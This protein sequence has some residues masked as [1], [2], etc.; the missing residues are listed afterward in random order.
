VEANIVYNQ[1]VTTFE[2]IL[3]SLS[4][5]YTKGVAHCDLK[6]K[7]FLV[8]KSLFLKVVITDFGLLKA[9]TDTIVLKTFCGTL[10]YLAS[11]AFPGICHDYDSSID[12]WAVGVMFFEWL[13]SILEPLA[14]PKPR[15]ENEKV[16]NHKWCN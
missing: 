13:Y 6:P 7:N 5:L 3:D 10:K 9:I 4:H 1:Y 12:V 15:N 16:L 11:E 8:E 14:A 2:Q